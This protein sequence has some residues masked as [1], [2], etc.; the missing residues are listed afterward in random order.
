MSTLDFARNAVTASNKKHTA[1]A[2][3]FEAKTKH[4]SKIEMV[5]QHR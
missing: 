4:H 3:V 2:G 5:T 1:P